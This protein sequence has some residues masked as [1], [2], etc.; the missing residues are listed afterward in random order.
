M[1]PQT[2]SGFSLLEIMIAIV[3]LSI[4]TFAL[5]AGMGTSSRISADTRAQ[6]RA[7]ATIEN[8]MEEIQ[9]KPLSEI[10]SYDNTV[11]DVYG[12]AQAGSTDQIA[13]QVEDLGGGLYQVVLDAEWLSQIGTQ[14][15]RLVFLQANRG[16]G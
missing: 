11:F 8:L 16:G 15:E 9:A 3:V 7:L 5:F 6:T 13:V 4:G 12:R 14:S 1:R 2:N 10:V